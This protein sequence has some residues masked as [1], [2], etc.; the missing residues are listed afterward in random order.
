M[1]LSDI[2]L[3]ESDNRNKVIES[4]GVFFWISNSIIFP[5]KDEIIFF[6]EHFSLLAH[7]QTGKGYEIV[8]N[9][10]ELDSSENVFRCNH[11]HLA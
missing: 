10:L 6:L 11:L 9:S 4:E 7:Y 5:I 1:E 8:R 2:F 3:L